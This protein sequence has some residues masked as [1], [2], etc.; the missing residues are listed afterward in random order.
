ME[1]GPMKMVPE[2]IE[3]SLEQAVSPQLPYQHL[4]SPGPFG[5]QLK[6]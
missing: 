4:V 6:L 2:M 5:I 3:L 1:K